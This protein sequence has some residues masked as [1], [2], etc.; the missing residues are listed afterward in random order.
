[1]TTAPRSTSFSARAGDGPITPSEL[2]ELLARGLRE[3]DGRS[4]GRC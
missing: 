1:M 4:G 2:P 3:K